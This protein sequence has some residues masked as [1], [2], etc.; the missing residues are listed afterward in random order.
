LENKDLIPFFGVKRQYANLR[1]EI[2]D[3]SDRVYQTGQVL[4]GSYTEEFERAIAKRCNR[5][6]AI[7]VNSCTQALIFA[8]NISSSSDSK[9]LIP[10][11]SFVATLNS[12][13]MNGKEPVFCDT[14]SN[15][16]MNI[17]SI[18]FALAGASV[19]T[20]MYANLWGHTIDWDRFRIN[21]EF[22]NRDLCII[23]DAAQSFGARYKGIPSGKMGDMSC[24][25][26]DPTKNLNNYGSGGMVL[27]DDVTLA[28]TLYDLRNNGKYDDHIYIGTN[29]KMS[30]SDCAQML[31]KL[32]Y[33]DRWQDRR[34]EIAEYYI[35][36][37]RDYVDCVLPGEDVESA[38]SKFVVKATGRHGLK[39]HLANNNIE[40]KL[41]YD[42]PLFELPV[43]QDFYDMVENPC[44]EAYAFTRECLSL[45]I[46]PELEDYEVERIVDCIQE[47]Y[48]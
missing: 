2:L 27:T 47:Y 38:W 4:D 36:E 10:A 26:F 32:Q 28:E 5:T 29:S 18:N 37:L 34:N 48:S 24:L 40:T 14:D 6:Y 21:T 41:N 46:Y 8:N 7:S 25:S 43:G 44:H 16:L 12:V 23:E 15:G 22:F 39:S 19:K 13:L 33:F 9:V 30:E 1:E 11:L 45:P 35:G 42:N 31:I 3:I 20:I 17:E